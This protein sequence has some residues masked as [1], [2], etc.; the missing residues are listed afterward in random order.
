[1]RAYVWVFDHPYF[2]VSKEDGSFSLPPLP[3]GT[4]TIAAWQEACVAQE[5]EAKVEAGGTTTL[6]LKFEMEKK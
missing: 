3:P 1:M 6:D 2:A 4:Y 5:H